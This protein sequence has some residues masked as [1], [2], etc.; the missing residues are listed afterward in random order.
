MAYYLGSGD[1]NGLRVGS[2]DRSWRRA[3]QTL[4]RRGSVEVI[5]E[6]DYPNPSIRPWPSRRSRERQL[7]DLNDAFEG[8]NWGVCLYPT[9]VIL[10]DVPEANVY[11]NEPYRQRLALGA[12]RLELAYF[13]L[14]VLESYRNDPMFS[15]SFGDSGV[16]TAISDDA[17]LA[18]GTPEHEKVLLHYLG[19][20]YAG[21]TGPGGPIKRCICGFLGDLS[22]LSSIHQQRW[23]TYELSDGDFQPHPLWWSAMMGHWPDGRGPFET[24]LYE[25]EVWN[26]LHERAFGERLLRTTERPREFG[27]ILR[28]SQ[29]E[30]DDFVQ[31]LDKLL[32]ENLRH[33]AFDAA[34][35]RRSEPKGQPLGTLKRLD[36]F[37]E[38]AA[39]DGEARKAV[40]RPLRDIRSAR[41]KPAHFLR[42]NVNDEALVRRQ[43]EILGEVSQSVGELRRFWQTH[44]RNRDWSEDPHLRDLKR[45]WL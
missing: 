32:S 7:K 45:Y 30:F 27:W 8:E 40:L 5:G 33:E 10:Q 39:V 17:Y 4:V 43:A 29:R 16:Q 44:P 31:Q 34:G 13:R 37:L 36:L 28:P 35:V 42:E 19:F 14:D 2:E 6:A 24:L 23:K 11:G 38:M 21:F 22:K 18:P 1:F 9:A 20:A 12:G 15:F 25:L 3:A 26:E 41:A